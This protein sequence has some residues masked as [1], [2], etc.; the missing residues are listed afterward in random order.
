MTTDAITKAGW[1]RH[2]LPSGDVVFYHDGRHEYF[3]D[4]K[5]KKDGTVS[6]KGRVQSVTSV[7]RPLDF[8]PDALMTY[9][10][11]QEAHGVSMLAADALSHEEIEDMRQALDWL[12]S[13]EAIRAALIDADLTWVDQRDKAGKRG[14]NV[15]KH[16]LHAMALGAPVPDFV[17]LTEEEQGYARG[18][19]K[20]WHE[21]EPMPIWSE[22]VAYSRIHNV[23]GRPDLVAQTNVPDRYWSLYDAKTVESVKDAF[24]P[25][26]HHAQ[27][28]M[29]DLLLEESGYGKT[30]EQWILL[31]DKN[32]DYDLV[33]CESTREE[34]LAALTVYRAASRI[35]SACAKRRRHDHGSRLFA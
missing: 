21:C 11:K 31:V 34:A 22:R 33:P 23:A 27:L 14:T 3:Q 12:M 18:V 6:G 9:A 1:E 20:F 16:A 7:I 15:H 13:G 29:Y 32:G 28:S 2:E 5:V 25:V 35:A 8:K 30:D 17:K 10:C 24:I 26:K 4:V 19:M